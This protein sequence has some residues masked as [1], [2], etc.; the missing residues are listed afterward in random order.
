MKD[1]CDEYPSNFHHLWDIKELTFNDV[2]IQ[3]KR[4]SEEG[5]F[6]YFIPNYIKIANSLKDDLLNNGYKLYNGVCGWG[7]LP[8]TTGLTIEW[9]P[10]IK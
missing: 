4:V 5:M 7:E 8:I 9:K 6:I 10:K 2:L 3:I 1:K